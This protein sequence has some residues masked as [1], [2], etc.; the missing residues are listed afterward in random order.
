MILTYVDLVRDFLH[1]FCG[2]LIDKL[3]IIIELGTRTASLVD[4]LEVVLMKAA[5]QFLIV[6]QHQL[7]LQGKD[8]LLI[9]MV[10]RLHVNTISQYHIL[11][12]AMQWPVHYRTLS[13]TYQTR[14]R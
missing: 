2:W 12:V 11:A 5:A 10:V 4:M 14:E 3:I 8:K 6:G 1:F 9:G 13:G 7:S